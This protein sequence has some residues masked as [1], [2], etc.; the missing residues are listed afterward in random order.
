VRRRRALVA[1]VLGVPAVILLL[2]AAGLAWVATT[3]TGSRW[4]VEQARA[5]L[6][7]DVEFGGF[8][9]VL[10]GPFTVTDVVVETGAARVQL[11]RVR[12]DWSPVEL[13]WSEI[14]VT[15]LEAVG[16]QVVIRAPD[17]PAAEAPLALPD[18]LV[19]PV[20]VV[21]ER[22]QVT[23]I[24]VTGPGTQTQRIQRVAMSAAAGP[25]GFSIE[26][27][28]VSAELG[29]ASG[30]IRLDADQP[31][32]LDGRIRWRLRL[33]EPRLPQLAGTLRLGGSLRRLQGRL[34]LAEPGPATLRVELRP[35]A[36]QPSWTGS[37]HL[38]AAPMDTWWS[39]A[40]PLVAGA[41][42]ELDGTPQAVRVR[43][44]T[45]L[46][47][48]PHG[49]LA[50]DLDLRVSPEA[51]TIRRVAVSA[52][53]LPDAS[54]NG[55]G[56][57]AIGAETPQ[58]DLDFEW[59]A[60]RW[61]LTGS[62]VAT[63]ESGALALS[64]SPD[65]YRLQADALV[66]TPQS[67]EEPMRVDV[68]ASGSTTG[69]S[70]V[71]ASAGWHEATLAARGD[72]QWTPDGSARLALDLDGLAPGRLVDTLEG[73]VAARAKLQ[74]RWGETVSATLDLE[75]LEG[76]LNGRPIE[77]DG[78]LRHEA[79]TTEVQSLRLRAGEAQ[80][81]ARGRAGEVLAFDWR[82]DV[83]EIGQLLP[84][85][86]GRLAARGRLEGTPG[87][88]RVVMQGMATGLVSPA[89]RAETVSVDGFVAP[90]GGGRTDLRVEAVQ[91]AAGGVAL[92]GLQLS[93][94]GTREQ[95]RLEASADSARG[96]ARVVLAGGL[97]DGRWA[98]RV[99]EAVLEPT[100]LAQW[101][102]AESMSFAVDGAG[103]ELDR[104]C[105]YSGRARLCAAFSGSVDAW[106]ARVDGE[107]IP[108]ALVGTLARDDLE[109]EGTFGFG[110]DL[111]GRGGMVT[112]DARVD[113]QPGRVT[114]TIEEQPEDLL[115]YRE[116]RIEVA[117]TRAEADVRADLQ[118]ADDGRVRLDAR[119]GRD[120]PHDLAGRIQARVE[121]LGLVTVLSPA[122]GRMK[123]TLLADLEL[124]GSLEDPS[125]AGSAELGSG[126]MEV[127]PLG[128]R[129]TDIDAD[130][131]TADRG[132]DITLRARS[133]GGP[134][135]L[136]A[137]VARSGGRW[138]GRGRISGTDF[139][140]VDLPEATVAVTPEIEWRLDGRDVTVEGAVEVPS[141]RI[142]PRDLSNTVQSSP[143][144]VIVGADAAAAAE[145]PRPFR[146]TADVRVLLGDSVNVDAFG[147]EGR[148]Q[149]QI[150]V[151]E[152]P[153]QVTEATG[154]LRVV[155]GTYGIY[156]QT[157]QIERGRLLFDGGPAANPG[158]DVR[159]VRRPRDVVVGVNVRGR[160]RE[161]RVTL[162]SEPPMQE[163]QQLSYLILGL[164]LNQTS[165]GQQSNLAVAA[166][167][168]AT[169][170]QGGRIAGRIGIQ[171]V[172]VDDGAPGEGASLVLGRYLSPR[173]YVGYGIGLMEQANSVRIR[174]DLTRYWTV[175][176]RSGVTS[177]AD[178]LYSIEV[179]R[180][181]EAISG[182]TDSSRGDDSPPPVE[183][184][185]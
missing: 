98:G 157:L 145:P 84:E 87:Q 44:N 36:E 80:L 139:E 68:A 73:R 120:A 174:Y 118:L 77:G 155:D 154:E 1:L 90:L 7:E 28:D 103:I 30:A 143:D 24:E 114:G 5:H 4:A 20:S 101:S 21:I 33:P 66:R 150:S 52:A 113:L 149:G 19:L 160:L 67:G 173:L 100:D 159:A 60:L 131:A 50:A 39:E 165:E 59:S 117:L 116:S 175:E 108:V 2:A 97:G 74:A 70:S 127:V 179:D 49:P 137:R 136:R 6:P 115:A 144:T 140:A 35:F 10:A 40:P 92:D 8:E 109:Y 88:P 166:A 148:L 107:R 134:V 45:R 51:L 69:F 178:L 95:H 142:A 96:R 128:I 99:S 31:F 54:L 56:R 25:G 48:L 58:F 151:I 53:Q 17:E 183:S 63:S 46:D 135:S 13:V 163:S 78:R 32:G 41:E 83:P 125:L 79:G 177:S 180:S 176:A 86:G 71:E 22:L 16:V 138:T 93:L 89:A 23:E 104:G 130:L 126:L 55:S 29:S 102:L 106:R 167:A 184:A 170:E 42:L 168:L 133:G 61:P 47:G 65:D 34:R 27:L 123:G 62:A 75:T 162:F 57:V 121:N 171:E 18:R 158:L 91:L 110:A 146:V 3:E 43:G 9:G 164:P 11:R 182:M 119:V 72:V 12:A 26:G 111:S 38:P 82:V 76:T 161:P 85:W 141:A 172:T 14:R 81:N 147:L 152:K 94:T 105:W 124:G 37:L 153:D 15:D 181:A 122:I 112:G 156:A 129:L 185:R 64:G 132:I 169:S